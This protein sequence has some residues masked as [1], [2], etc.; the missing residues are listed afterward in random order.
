MGGGT[1][2]GS[3]VNCSS[4]P[5]VKG[6]RGANSPSPERP[7]ELLLLCCEPP[8]SQRGSSR[9]LEEVGEEAF[10]EE[11]AV[12]EE[13]EEAFWEEAVGEEEEAVGK[14]KA[15]REEG[16]GEE[17]EAVR[18]EEAFG[19]EVAFGEEEEESPGRR[20]ATLPLSN[21]MGPAERTGGSLASAQHG[22]SSNNSSNS[23][24]SAPLLWSRAPRPRDAHQFRGRPSPMV[25]GTTPGAA[26]LRPLR[27][28]TR[29][30]NG[31][32]T[33]LQSAADQRGSGRRPSGMLPEDGDDRQR[34]GGWSWWVERAGETGEALFLPVPWGDAL[35]FRAERGGKRG[36]RE[37]KQEGETGRG[38]GAI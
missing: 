20:E 5:P 16:F 24:G 3:Q 22:G 1:L 29:E 31:P 19:E 2:S 34:G 9:S 11:E 37:G 6:R 30:T 27:A 4:D 28:E 38:G 18:E 23:L 25:D 32:C 35:A 12:G 36:K 13:E 8:T 33:V 21:I 14:E 15:F 10:W 7:L 17:E 26:A